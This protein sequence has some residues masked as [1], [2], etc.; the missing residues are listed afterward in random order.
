MSTKISLKVPFRVGLNANFITLS[1]SLAPAS[2]H[3]SVVISSPSLSPPDVVR[4]QL[5]LRRLSTRANS[6]AFLEHEEGILYPSGEG[7]GTICAR[8]SPV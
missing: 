1:D 6:S 4:I 7:Q 3:L 8:L 5:R 2:L